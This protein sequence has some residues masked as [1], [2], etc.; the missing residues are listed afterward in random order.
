MQKKKLFSWSLTG[1]NSLKWRQMIA[2]MLFYKLVFIYINHMTQS[3]D[4]F[5]EGIEEGVFLQKFLFLVIQ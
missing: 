4:N 3:G 1:L 5:Y 2:L